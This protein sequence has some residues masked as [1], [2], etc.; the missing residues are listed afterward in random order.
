MTKATMRKNCMT[1]RHKQFCQDKSM[2]RDSSQNQS[3]VADNQNNDTQVEEN[4]IIL[5]GSFWWA[6]NGKG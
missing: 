1:K 3:K 4:T 5:S 2:R 6:E